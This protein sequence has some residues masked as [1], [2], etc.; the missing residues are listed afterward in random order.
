VAIP[1][2]EVASAYISY[3][4]LTIDY[5]LFFTVFIRVPEGPVVK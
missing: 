4:L 2:Q 1:T 3:K 5:R